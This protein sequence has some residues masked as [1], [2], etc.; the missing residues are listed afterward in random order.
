MNATLTA[1]RDHPVSHF[2][3]GETILE[4]GDCTGLLYVLIEGDVEVVKDGV[5]VA[6]ASEPGAT[7]G[8]LSALL[9]VPHTAAVRARGVSCF[10]VISDPLGFLEEH[11][12]ACLQLCKLLARRLD[13][14]NQYLTDVKQQ[15]EGHDHLAMV[16]G[17]L[18]TLMHRQPRA[19]MAPQP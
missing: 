15:F 16:D 17:L 2:K 1:L 9:G 3:A 4:Q 13:A 12:P 14:V 11:P 7:F 18:D 6:K 8:D 19:R 5:R 10:Y